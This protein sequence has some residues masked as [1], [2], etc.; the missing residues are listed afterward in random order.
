MDQREK[1]QCKLENM[2]DLMKIPHN[3]ICEIAF[4]AMLTWNYGFKHK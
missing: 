4:E 3:K 1:S 2:S